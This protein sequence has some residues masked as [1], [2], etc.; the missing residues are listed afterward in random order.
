MRE[1][2]DKSGLRSE[3]GYDPFTNPKNEVDKFFTSLMEMLQSKYD[4]GYDNGY[5]D[6]FEEAKR[7]YKNNDYDKAFKDGYDTGFKMGIEVGRATHQVPTFE[8]FEIND[9]PPKKENPGRYTDKTITNDF[10]NELSNPIFEY[11]TMPNPLSFL[12]GLS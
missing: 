12:G 2:L 8:K 7:M 1:R 4:N 11:K 5:N 3:F 6:G 9:F 10:T